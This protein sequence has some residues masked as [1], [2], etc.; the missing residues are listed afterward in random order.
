MTIYRFFFFFFTYR[1]RNCLVVLTLLQYG[2]LNWDMFC[3]STSSVHP[4]HQCSVYLFANDEID[5]IIHM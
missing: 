3:P 5:K 4:V 1:L 2:G